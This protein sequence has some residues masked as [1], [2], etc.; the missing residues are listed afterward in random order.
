MA[1][2]IY[3]NKFPIFPHN[4]FIYFK[5]TIT[6]GTGTRLSHKVYLAMLQ[7]AA[8]QANG[9]LGFRTQGYNIG[10]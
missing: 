5:G 7:L 8:E 6:P 1:L 10:V 9:A 4:Y 3:A 2:G